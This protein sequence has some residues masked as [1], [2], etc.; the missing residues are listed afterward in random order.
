[1]TCGG[2]QRIMAHSNQNLPK[3]KEQ[4]EVRTYLFS[5]NCGSFGA[6]SVPRVEPPRLSCCKHGASLSTER[7][8]RI[9]IGD[10]G[11]LPLVRSW[12]RVD[13]REV[14]FSK[15]VATV[16]FAKA[17]KNEIKNGDESGLINNAKSQLTAKT[18]L[19][20]CIVDQS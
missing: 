16:I 4:C 2:T 6:V 20:A 13:I 1:M 14:A 11:Y 10:Y 8:Q 18:R 19:M 3:S 9:C 5:R 7:M 17:L 12:D 15:T